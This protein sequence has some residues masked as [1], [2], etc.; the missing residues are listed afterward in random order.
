MRRISATALAVLLVGLAT[1]SAC[2][3]SFDGN[4]TA[5]GQFKCTP[6]AGGCVG[7]DQTCQQHESGEY[8]VCTSSPTCIDEDG[9]GYGSPKNETFET[10]DACEE[11]LPG[12]CDP[13]CADTPDQ[14]PEGVDPAS[15]HPGAAEKCDG[16]DNDCDQSTGMSPAIDPEQ[17][18]EGNPIGFQECSGDSDCP[19]AGEVDTPDSTQWTCEEID[20]TPQC[21]LIG[22]FNGKGQCSSKSDS[23][24]YGTCNQD[25]E[26]GSIGWSDV[27]QVCRTGNTDDGG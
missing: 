18:E 6:D 27:P 13:D 17:S 8:Y 19:L 25:D 1:F 14:T 15:I 22:N 16:V 2:S 23:E 10:C 4:T 12:G 26:A 5:D 3:V 24:R 20:G 21:V 9:D 7:Q 11:G